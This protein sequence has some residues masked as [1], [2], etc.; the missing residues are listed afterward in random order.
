[1][2]SLKNRMA[3]FEKAAGSSDSKPKPVSNKSPKKLGASF[4]ATMMKIG[5]T[6]SPKKQKKPS[7]SPS[8]TNG[9]GSSPKKSPK[10]VGKLS[11]NKMNIAAML[12]F[13]NGGGRGGGPRSGGGPSSG[14]NKFAPVI[15][16]GGR[17]EKVDIRAGSSIISQ[18]DQSQQNMSERA[19]NSTVG[20]S[21]D[22]DPDKED[23]DYLYTLAVQYDQYKAKETNQMKNPNSGPKSE[24]RQKA[25]TKAH[26]QGDKKNMKSA[27]EGLLGGPA[28]TVKG[29]W[30]NDGYFDQYLVEDKQ[31][32]S[33]TFDFG[34]QNKV[35][36]RFDRKDAE[37]KSMANMY[38]EAL[39]KHPKS[40]DI[41][42]L[43]M[44]NALLPDAFFVALATQC[45]QKNGLPKVQAMNFESNLM[46]NEGAEALATAI[47]D[48]GVWKNLQ[49]LKLENQKMQLGSDSENALGEA[50]L[51]SPSLV[52]VS[53][54][55]QDG[56]ARQQI[57]N[58]TQANMDKL[59]QARRKHAAKT[60]T[61]KERKRNEMEVHF[62]KIADN[63]DPSITDVD[64][65]G[66]IKYLGL[67]PT[68]RKKSGLAFK[69]NTTVRTLKMVKLK[70]DD[71]FAKA[72]GEALAVNTT[73]EKV[74]VDSNEFSGAGIKALFEGLG[75]N[76]SIVDFQVRHQTKTMASA[77]E[78]ALPDLLTDNNTCIKIGVDARNAQIKS[79]LDRKQS[80]NREYQRKQRVAAKKNQ[81]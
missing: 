8:K 75:K 36:K 61:L 72:L 21:K 40:K 63:S 65:V 27:L 2:S 59:R 19:K 23:W 13:G 71:E 73:L 39:I 57:N 34:G 37:Q 46:H 67:N 62:D 31:F 3:A 11:A 51:K 42:I 1:M 50:T 60:G 22:V 10:K 48:P 32:N 44:N 38:V 17:P 33:L 28:M 54:R 9:S 76:T 24:A 77:D 68:E 26:E 25:P 79:L 70:L 7:V 74:I 78:Q 69:T 29:D 53:L 12:P 41:T 49:I 16:P 55:V 4:G 58:S 14:G 45:I 56:L 30:L 5:A 43:D 64:I 66:N 15:K 47:A 80:A 18:A 81:M 52:V 6:L 20:P 35:F